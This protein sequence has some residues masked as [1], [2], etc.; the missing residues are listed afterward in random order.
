MRNTEWIVACV[1]LELAACAAPATAAPVACEALKGQAFEATT[2]AS[3]E[4]VAAGAFKPSMPG[5]PANYATLP[6]FCRVTGSIRPTADSDIRFEVWLPAAAW[7]GKFV[8]VGNGGAAGSIVHGALAQALARGY[9]TANTDMG[10]EGTGG[11]FSWALGHPEKVTDYAWR[12]F[13]LLTGVGKAITAA[14]YGRQPA[15]SYWYGCSTGGRQGLKEAQRFPEDYDAIVAGAPASNWAPLMSLAIEVQRNM[16]GP[17]GL[18]IDK[19]ALLKESAIAACDAADDVK[20]RV[21]TDPRRCA[22]DPGSLA[23]KAGETS[24][25]LS[26]TEVDAARRIYRGVVDSKGKVRFPGTGPGSELQWAGYASPQFRIGTSYFGNI[27]AKDPAWDPA[28][29]DV[30]RDVPRISAADAGA[31]AAMDPDIG[32]FIARGGRLLTYHGTTDGLIPFGNSVN[33]F[34]SVVAKMGAARVKDSV[35]FYAVPGMD[36]CSGGEGP[37][38]VDWLGALDRW[39]ET[40]RAPDALTGSHPAVVPARPGAPPSTPY[41]RPLC[42]WPQLAKYKGSGDTTDA[43]NF[44]CAAP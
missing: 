37:F 18:G 24:Q 29:F 7:N 8:Q 4:L 44:Q 22:F 6:A 31:T 14:H 33:Y 35:R 32:R 13:H 34:E 41:T 28:S 42:P 11:D 27:V 20:D 16:T 36:H 39:V 1:V 23:C 17:R 40:G 5:P 9:A 43:A 25:C 10:H 21:I 3:A 26:P 38:D 30:D 15:K 19:L 12:S 2:I